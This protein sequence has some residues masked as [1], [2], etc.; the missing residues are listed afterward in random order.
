MSILDNELVRKY[1]GENRPGAVIHCDDAKTFDY[2]CW[3]AKRVLDAM[4]QPIEKG[5][6]YLEWIYGPPDSTITED[7]FEERICRGISGTAPLGQIEEF[8]D[9]FHPRELCLPDAFQKQKCFQTSIMCPSCHEPHKII[10]PT[11]SLEKCKCNCH[12]VPFMM[13]HYCC[14]IADWFA[15]PKD[16]AE[17]T[18]KDLISLARETPT[19][20]CCDNGNFGA[21]HHCQKQPCDPPGKP[22]DAVEEKI[23]KIVRS[24]IWI[25]RATKDECRDILRDLVRLARETK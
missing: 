8:F 19:G 20:E 6:R 17:G 3:L 23:E 4:Q 22:K 2:E 18:I 25:A 14:G 13:K 21:A 24:P 10:K 7:H 11:P 9:R 15:K 5:K 1:F 12:R 16:F